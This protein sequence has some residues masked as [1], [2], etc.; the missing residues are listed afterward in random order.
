M[1]QKALDTIKKNNLLMI[2]LFGIVIAVLVYL[3]LLFNRP[4]LL[5]YTLLDIPIKAN[6]RS[7]AP[8]KNTD[9]LPGLKNGREYAYSF[10]IYLDDIDNHN[11]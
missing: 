8:L 11:S 1:G 5:Y 2:I 9:K 6:S 4:S 10:W 7:L 3:I